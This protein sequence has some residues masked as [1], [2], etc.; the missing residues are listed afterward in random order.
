MAR[1]T[2]KSLDDEVP[3]KFVMLS[4]SGR[5]E[6]FA[7]GDESSL[8]FL[9]RRLLRSNFAF[10]PDATRR[11][12][13]RPRS[14]SELAAGRVVVV[15]DAFTTGACVAAD[16]AARGFRVAH[17]LSLGDDSGMDIASLIPGHLKGAIQWAAEFG[18]DARAPLEAS[19]A[20]VADDLRDWCDRDGAEVAAVVAGAET[21]V[22]LA[23]CLSE[24]VA[25]W[26]PAVR[27]NGA[28]GAEARRNKWDMGEK[29]RGAGVRA[30][31]QLRSAGWDA[32]LE[33]WLRD[34]W[35]VDPADDAAAVDLIVKPTESAGSDGVT[36]CKTVGAVRAAV[37][38]LLSAPNALGQRN[39]QVLIQEFLR[40]DEYVV[41]SA[42]RDGVHKVVGMWL[43]DRKPTNGAGFV[44]HGQ[45]FV[46]GGEAVV[47]LL[48]AYST[49]VLDALE[50][51]HGPSH[52][53]VKLAPG[54][55]GPCLVE[56]AVA[57][58]RPPAAA[59]GRLKYLLFHK[60]GTLADI[61]AAVVE[62]ITALPSYRGHEFFV[63]A[64]AAVVPTKDC[65]TWGGVVKL[66]GAD[67]A[68]VD[69]D[70]AFLADVSARDPGL[71]VI[72]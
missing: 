18:V 49:T 1:Q 54:S 12:L 15:V 47:D 23:D 8:R 31:R 40:G 68:Q 16:A 33:R 36:G 38:A 10:S 27:T 5:R 51:K 11:R 64:G 3:R 17:V 69:R 32:T 20:D 62:Q 35:N 53:E 39:E 63:A 71:W 52:M 25:R 65:F 14:F 4:V 30:V 42:S 34:D 43:Y 9:K 2:S 26:A 48:A 37:G 60:G 66:N 24:A 21:G 22:K 44:C 28:A 57:A 41:D 50:L 72:A 70:Y 13:P 56:R 55:G 61:D 46:G 7:S 67:E 45:R 59:R 29:V 19:A 58:P 6:T